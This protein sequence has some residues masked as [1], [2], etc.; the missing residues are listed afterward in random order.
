MR[1]K[2]PLIFFNVII[3]LAI[4]VGSSSAVFSAENKV[5]EFDNKNV[6]TN[7]SI[8]S[9]IDIK[10]Q[11]IAN[12]KYLLTFITD[13][14][15]TA[16][17]QFLSLP[18][19]IFITFKESFR[20]KVPAST[21]DKMPVSLLRQIRYLDV[22][23]DN[24]FFKVSVDLNKQVFLGKAYTRY[25]DIQVPVEDSKKQ[26]KV[27]QSTSINMKGRKSDRYKVVNDRT[28][29]L[30]NT[31]ESDK[32]QDNEF[33]VVKKSQKF[34]DIVD[35]VNLKTKKTGEKRYYLFTIEISTDKSEN[36]SSIRK[37][38][39]MLASLDK[40]NLKKIDDNNQK[41]YTNNRIAK[42]NNLFEFKLKN[43]L[44]FV[45][46]KKPV[47]DKAKR[48]RPI[49]VMIDPGHGGKDPGASNKS[50]GLVEKNLVLE[51]AH[52][53][54]EELEKNPEI[55][56]VMTR[57][58]DYF[59]PLYDRVLWTQYL[60]AD[61]FISLHADSTEINTKSRGM[62]LYH[63]SEVASDAQTQLLMNDA[64]K[65]GLKAGN[66]NNDTDEE[67]SKILISMLQRSKVNNSIYLAQSIL[68]QYT[69]LLPVLA[70]PLR[71]A[72]FAVLK[73]PDVPSLLVE[74]GFLSNYSDIEMFKTEDYKAKVS[75]AL[76]TGI[77]YFL[78]ES[79]ILNSFPADSTQALNNSLHEFG[80]KVEEK[81][82]S[83]DNEALV[84]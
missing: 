14:P 15:F 37:Y 2:L 44:N 12:N 51:V 36:S 59:L 52:K 34:D 76:S 16:K 82:Q 79:G 4:L 7:D 73:V 26:E 29:T 77:E 62:S 72:D 20:W 60:Q 9:I 5:I 61:L 55:V 35:E 28:V 81:L 3:F 19:R 67:V 50:K 75:L 58:D 13:A 53:L 42:R 54:K 70:S 8:G 41:I 84:K 56:V 23:K 22:R 69:K 78:W 27:V 46:Y 25:F 39:A 66:I 80:K 48:N 74:L 33:E 43:Y 64:N 17:L 38:T 11:P 71:G 10:F 21:I 47:L 18:N 24:A 40:E 1:D 31:K 45:N 57:D 32:L 30:V 83:F 49:I 65:L 6:P 63:L 68:D